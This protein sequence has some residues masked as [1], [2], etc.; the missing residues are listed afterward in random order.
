MV[1]PYVPGDVMEYDNEV[2]VVHD[3]DVWVWYLNCGQIT[4]V[5]ASEAHVPHDF[6]CYPLVNIQKAMEN[7]NFQ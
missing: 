3:P 5:D 4:T 2:S 7:H 6:C 1:S